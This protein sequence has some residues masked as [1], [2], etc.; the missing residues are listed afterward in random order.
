MSAIN[1]TKTETLFP[2]AVTNVFQTIHEKTTLYSIKAQTK[3]YLPSC[4]LVLKPCKITRHFV[5]NLIQTIQPCHINSVQ[6][7]ANFLR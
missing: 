2:R 7:K 3:I 4:E 5:Q 1:L 6:I